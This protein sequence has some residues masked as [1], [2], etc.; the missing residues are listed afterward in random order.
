MW[1][2]SPAPCFKKQ[3]PLSNLPDQNMNGSPASHKYQ[4][5]MCSPNACTAAQE[6]FAAVGI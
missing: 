1:L 4:Q 2:L 5:T 6:K 3:S